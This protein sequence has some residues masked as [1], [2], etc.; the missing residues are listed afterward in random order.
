MPQGAA[1]LRHSS[2]GNRSSR[3]K[4]RIEHADGVAE[5]VVNQRKAPPIDGTFEALG[6]FPFAAGQAATVTVTNE[7]ADGYVV[8]DAVQWLPKE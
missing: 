5:A 3:V 2:P 8:I 1:L 4:V 6:T 7:G